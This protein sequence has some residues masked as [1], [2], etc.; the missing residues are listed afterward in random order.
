MIARASVLAL[1]LLGAASLM[2]ASAAVTVNGTRIVYD[3]SK[4]ATTITATNRGTRPALAQTWLDDGN[5]SAAPGSQ[6]LPLMLTPS[7]RRL[8]AGTSQNY[9]LTYMPTA[10]TPLPENRESVLFFN[11]L[12]I[13]PKADKE[14]GSILQFAVR[15][16]LKLFYRPAGLQG[17]PS[18]AAASLVWKAIH[19]VDGPALEVRNPSSFHVSFNKIIL[20]SGQE[21]SAEMVAP[22]QT[23][24]IPLPAGASTPTSFRFEWLDDHG[25]SRSQHVTLGT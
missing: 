20:Q 9:R 5:E 17:R 8:E 14:D 7:T 19:S 3:A 2:P 1:A 25:A 6:K 4:G 23:R 10:G 15:T 16:R 13:P 22:G 21:I 11:L 24:L 12:D 18:E